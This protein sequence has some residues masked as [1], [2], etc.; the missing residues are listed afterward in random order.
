MLFSTTLAILTKD[1]VFIIPDDGRELLATYKFWSD[2]LYT[3]W[4]SGVI[5]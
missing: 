3:F 1:G 5:V 4:I 2:S